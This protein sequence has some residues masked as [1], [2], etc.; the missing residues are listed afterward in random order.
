MRSKF[1]LVF[2]FAICAGVIS[3][4][5]WISGP[6]IP[7]WRIS[8]ADQQHYNLLV[9]GFRD[10]HLF[11][12]KAPAPEL[13]MLPDLYDPRQNAPYRFQDASYYRGNYYLYFGVTP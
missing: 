11:L 8:S 2:L 4:Y 1:E 7:Q 3:G 6:A 5:F 10:G 9:E 12:Q 13:A